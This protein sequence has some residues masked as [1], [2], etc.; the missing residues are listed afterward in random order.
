M[1][2]TKIKF[3]QVCERSEMSWNRPSKGV[4]LCILLDEESNVVL[5]RRESWQTSEF[6]QNEQHMF[7]FTYQNKD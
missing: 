7:H 4:S 6:I 3:I 1:S 2:L 5:V